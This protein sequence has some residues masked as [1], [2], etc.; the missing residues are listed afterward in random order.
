MSEIVYSNIQS[1][2]LDQCYCCKDGGELW[3]WAVDDEFGPELEVNCN[4]SGGT[5]TCVVHGS[6]TPC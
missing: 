1:K 6:P 4:R 3:S 5:T 2:P